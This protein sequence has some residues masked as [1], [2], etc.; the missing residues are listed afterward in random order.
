MKVTQKYEKKII[1]D[2][3]LL[4]PLTNSGLKEALVLNK[5]SVYI[6]GLIEQGF[7]KEEI[8][9]QCLKKYSVEE[10]MLLSDIENAINL[11]IQK[12]VVME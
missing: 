6:F 4:L 12:N 7:S 11:L 2:E 8:F 10:D 9:N 1:G 5:T 3:I